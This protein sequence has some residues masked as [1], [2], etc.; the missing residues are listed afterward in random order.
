[1]TFEINKQTK[2]RGFHK[3]VGKNLAFIEIFYFSTLD[4]EMWPIY[5]PLVTISTVE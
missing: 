5:G 3:I 4:L 1:M 2:L